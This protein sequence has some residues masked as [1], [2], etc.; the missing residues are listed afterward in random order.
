VQY[1]GDPRV[2]GGRHG[3][4]A[5]C[6][7]HRG[8]GAGGDALDRPRPEPGEAV[9]EA[10]AT[11]HEDL[12]STGR[13]VTL[14]HGRLGPE[15]HGLRYTDAGHG[16]ML[17][18]RADGGVHRPPGGGL[19]LGNWPDRRWDENLIELR[20]GD[21]ML[22]FSDGLLD[23]YDGTLTALDRSLEPPSGGKND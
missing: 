20:P 7:H 14:C 1:P 21:T 2:R 19:P 17:L 12:E 4:G 6:L 13:L 5:G 16:L 3:Q 11:L 10:A 9:N 23:L 8:D 15:Q 22:A 18:V